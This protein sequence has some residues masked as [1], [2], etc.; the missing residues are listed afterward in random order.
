[1]IIVE[2]DTDITVTGE[3]NTLHAD[4]SGTITLPSLA[5]QDQLTQVV[6]CLA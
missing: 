6:L 3:S 2:N 1:M 4:A 5:G